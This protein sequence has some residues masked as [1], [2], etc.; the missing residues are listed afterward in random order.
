MNF[1]AF[2]SLSFE[3]HVCVVSSGGI[4]LY[5]RIRTFQLILKSK[6][7]PEHSFCFSMAPLGWGWV[8]APPLRETYASHSTSAYAHTMSLSQP[9]VIPPQSWHLP[10]RDPVLGRILPPYPRRHLLWDCFPKDVLQPL[11]SPDFWAPSLSPSSM[12]MWSLVHGLR[13]GNRHW[14]TVPGGRWSFW[15]IYSVLQ[16]L[17]LEVQ[18][19]VP[20]TALEL[21]MAS[22]TPTAEMAQCAW[23]HH[24]ER[25]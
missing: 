5:V 16:T 25:N 7:F 4:T 9:P 23:T 11:S 12:V 15:L 10:R 1:C 2:L 19:R 21:Q 8:A 18:P 17:W 14:N 3:A 13:E 6:A 24:L 20:P 22:F